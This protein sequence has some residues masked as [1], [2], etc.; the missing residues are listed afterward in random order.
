MCGEVRTLA[1][2]LVGGCRPLGGGLHLGHLYGCLT[3]LELADDDLYYFVISDCVVGDHSQI[4]LS[5]REICLD[6]MAW[7]GDRK[8]V[9]LVRESRL[10]SALRPLVTA[11]EGTTSLRLVEAAHPHRSSLRA[12]QYRGSLGDFL[13]PIHQTSFLLGLGCN[14]AC[15]N[16]DNRTIVD[17]ARKCARKVNRLHN[18]DTLDESVCL[19]PRS[20]GRLLGADG[21]RMTKANQNCLMLDSDRPRVERFI[22]KLVGHAVG[23]GVALNPSVVTETEQSYFSLVPA[24][25]D[26]IS[27]MTDGWARIEALTEGLW[28]TLK[29]FKERRSDIEKR[30]DESRLFDLLDEGERRAQSVIRATTEGLGI[31]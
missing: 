8:R 21:R 18:R 24:L 7:L 27:I 25:I 12:G 31:G 4:E 19:I 15:Y 5:T 26:D 10:R 14:V 23:T 2:V 22:K 30:F 29:D 11:L 16:D 17:L 13:F 6:V 3:S 9:C 20:P 28:A 1:R